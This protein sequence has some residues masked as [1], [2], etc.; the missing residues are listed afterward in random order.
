MV[1]GPLGR[2]WLLTLTATMLDIKH[3]SSSWSIWRKLQT[4]DTKA[5]YISLSSIQ[6]LQYLNRW[7]DEKKY[8]AMKSV[9]ATLGGQGRLPWFGR[10]NLLPQPTYL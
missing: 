7:K 10:N 3:G 4:S 6:V 9:C 1:V 2:L 8:H 5:T